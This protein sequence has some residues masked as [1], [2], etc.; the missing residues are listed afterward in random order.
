MS[1]ITEVIENVTYELLSNGFIDDNTRNDLIKHVRDG[2]IADTIIRG[3]AKG[4]T[5]Y[6]L[7][8]ESD[9]DDDYTDLSDFSSYDGM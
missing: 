6:R 4:I 2:R 5:K 7:E 9:E 1:K 3:I 8:V